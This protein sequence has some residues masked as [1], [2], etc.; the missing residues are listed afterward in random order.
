M[1]KRAVPVFLVWIFLAALSLLFSESASAQTCP[2]NGTLSNKLVCQIP[3]VYGA[4][5]FGT[6]T[7]PT[8]SVLF[9]GDHHQAHFSSDFLATFAPINEAVGIQA[10]QLPIAS[11]SSG[12]TFVYD[13]S[14]KTFAPST[15]ESLGPVVGNRAT[16][17]G[18]RKLFLGFSYQYFNFSTI[19]G[20]SLSNIPT[21]LQHQPFPVPNPQHIPSC[22][23]QTGLTTANGYAG[24]P[25][26]VRD[27][28]QT[29]NNVDLTI[30]QYTIYVTYGITNRLDFSAAIPILN[31]Q[32]SVSSQATIV[33]NTVTP[34]AVGAPGNVWHSFNPTNPVLASQCASQVPCLSA[35]FT[36][37]N[38]AAGIGDVVLRGKYNIYN[39]ERFAVAAGV[40]V[41]LPTGD[42]L[43]FLGS[44]AT[45]V[46]PFGVVSY[47]ARISPHAQ[48]GY[49]WNGDS[50][51]AGTSI[52]PAPAGTTPVATG[53]LPNRFVYVVGA[54]ARILKRLTA[55]FDIY[56]QRLFNSPELVSQPYTDLGHCAGPT[57]PTGATCGTYT[58]GTIHPDIAQRTTDY[59]ITEASLGLKYRLIGR[60]V[61][62]GNVLFK[63][64]DGGL[65]SKVIPLVGASYNF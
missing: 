57:D 46:Q 21:V 9:S 12:I 33:P 19:D 40:D 55:A 34:A 24:D 53:K 15:D 27:F 37:A 39:G 47:K 7:D 4:F 14:L 52:V 65:R 38:S 63:L 1:C 22:D 35:T 3:Q 20:Q 30:H 48:V 26:F 49:E 28:I 6:T 5:G 10:S 59:N 18:R 62:T 31:V 42:A 60:L 17:I 16:T 29:R 58:A 23:N 8:Q 41:R 11:P 43:N 32:M 64:D 54:D 13:P 2:L 25:C 44:G 50:A 51:L 56:G 45:G 61:I 36:D